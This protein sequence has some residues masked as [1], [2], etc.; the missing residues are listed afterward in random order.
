MCPNIRCDGESWKILQ[1]FLELNRALI[2]I[3][4][5]MYYYNNYP[6]N[7]AWIYVFHPLLWPAGAHLVL[8]QRTRSPARQSSEFWRPT[9]VRARGSLVGSE[10]EIASPDSKRS[11]ATAQ[12]T[13]RLGSSVLCFTDLHLHTLDGRWCA[14]L[15]TLPLP[16][17]S[18]YLP[19]TPLYHTHEHPHSAFKSIKHTLTF[20]PCFIPSVKP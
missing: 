20:F 19:R 2:H 6:R 18:Y 4:V 14:L 10:H 17:I 7:L 16:P 9:S 5:T 1:N 13:R 15:H 11:P 8:S 3:P 12:A